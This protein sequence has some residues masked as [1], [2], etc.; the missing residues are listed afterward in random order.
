MAERPTG[1]G[2]EPIVPSDESLLQRMR[3]GDEDAFTVLYRR[4]RGAV[5]RFA[6]HMSGS[7]A[8]AEEVAQEVFMVLIKD[9]RN[10]DARRGSLGSW[11][12]GI[13]RN[14]TL[15]CLERDRSFV[16]IGEEFGNGDQVPAELIVSGDTLSEMARTERIDGLRKAILALPAR[17]REAVVLCDLHEMSYAEAASVTGSA[18]GT[19]RS[20]LHRARALLLEKLRAANTRCLA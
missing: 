16:P 15:R 19:I 12:Y 3:K 9:T 5:Y 20:R 8:V 10:Y 2:P 1:E 13:A 11:L 7:A 4:H 18:V 14:F 6:L 17:Y